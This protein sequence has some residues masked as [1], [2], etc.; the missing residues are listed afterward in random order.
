V[1]VTGC[2][3]IGSVIA[4]GI[5]SRL[6]NG[7]GVC[8][9]SGAALGSGFGA[10]LGTGSGAAPGRGSGATTRDVAGGT[11]GTLVPTVSNQ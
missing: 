1:S 11:L 5:D 4:A 3:R 9:T 10:G 6:G 2:D 8:G 7:G